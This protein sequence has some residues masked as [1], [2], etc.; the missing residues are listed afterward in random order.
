MFFFRSFP[1]SHVLKAM[2]ALGV[3][4]SRAAT[5]VTSFDTQA[6]RDVNY[7][8]HA[9]PEPTAIVSRIAQSFIRFGTL[10]EESA[11]QL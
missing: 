1:H 4:T 7:D 8:G 2:F 5:L 11:K 6:V 9:A 3:P 10:V